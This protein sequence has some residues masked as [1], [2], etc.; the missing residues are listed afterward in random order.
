[1]HKNIVWFCFLGGVLAITLWFT[2]DATLK[3]YRY[4]SLKKQIPAKAVS[5]SIKEI[6]ED[7]YYPHAHYS[8]IVKDREY[9]SDQTLKSLTYR[10]PWAAEEG[11]EDLNKKQWHVWYDPKYPK[12]SSLENHFPLKET[13]SAGVLIGL[14]LYFLGLGYYVAHR[15]NQDG[16]FK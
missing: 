6:D 2:G 16:K 4:L 14:T 11:L 12:Y 3:L 9:E 5:W 13:L 7:L 15:F 8:F 10:N 1:M